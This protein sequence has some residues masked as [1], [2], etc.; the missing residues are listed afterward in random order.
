MKP[1]ADLTVLLALLLWT[2]AAWP[3]VTGGVPVPHHNVNGLGCASCHV[4]RPG[5]ALD[6]PLDSGHTCDSALLWD[7]DLPGRTFRTYE[8]PVT[9][10]AAAP[11]DDNDM[12][13][14]SMLCASCHDGVGTPSMSRTPGFSSRSGSL[15]GKGLQTEHPINVPHDP[16]KDP[17]L[18]SLAA[19]NRLVKLFGRQ[20]TVQCSSCHD[21]HDSPNTHS[22]R[23]ANQDSELCLTCH[24]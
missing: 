2:A 1:R 14:A 11:T 15:A 6:P 9:H 7:C 12:R 21:P 20:N 4:A 16:A 22:L 10:K 13:M 24:L 3:Q 19:V 23:M 8:Q 18:A 17:T 5:P